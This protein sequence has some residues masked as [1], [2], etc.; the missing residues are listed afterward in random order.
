MNSTP[1]RLVIY[2]SINHHHTKCLHSYSSRSTYY[3][4]VTAPVHIHTL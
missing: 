2:P 4:M 3:F 1:H